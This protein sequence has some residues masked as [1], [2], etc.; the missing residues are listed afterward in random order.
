MSRLFDDDKHRKCL[1]RSLIVRGSKLGCPSLL[2]R[3]GTCLCIRQDNVRSRRRFC[4]SSV[5]PHLILM[6]SHSILQSDSQHHQAPI[7]SHT[8]RRQHNNRIPTRTKFLAAQ[9]VLPNL[10]KELPVPLIPPIQTHQQYP[11]PIRREQRT[12][13]VEFRSEDL[14]HHKCE[15]ELPKRGSY[16]CAFEGP[17][18]GAH[19][20]ESGTC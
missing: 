10:T 6:S 18:R 19:F 20:D 17:L 4:I 5:W 13:R 12:Y 9:S 8:Q 11:N 3:S 7:R 15:R 16:I 2:S 14:E 1:V